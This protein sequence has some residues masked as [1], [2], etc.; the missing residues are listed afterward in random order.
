MVTEVARSSRGH[1][2]GPR[3]ALD[4]DLTFSPCVPAARGSCLDVP[5]HLRSEAHQKRG[6]QD[7]E[8]PNPT[9]PGLSRKKHENVLSRVGM[10]FYDSTKCLIVGTSP[11]TSMYQLEREAGSVSGHP[12]LAAWWWQ[13]LGG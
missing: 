2:Q 6:L 9:C 13:L 11:T 10:D 12:V 8:T 4:L 1:T 5:K 7:S 3:L